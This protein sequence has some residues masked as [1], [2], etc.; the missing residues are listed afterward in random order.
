MAV[1]G[2]NGCWSSIRTRYFDFTVKHFHE[3]L[4]AE[5][6]FK[7]GYSWTKRMLQDA[8]LVKRAAKR[9]AHGASGRAGRCRA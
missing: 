9:G 5:H 7:L 4:R 1:D 8:G 2:A 6:G 3:K